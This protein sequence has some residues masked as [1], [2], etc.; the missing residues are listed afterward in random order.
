M[1][2]K[3]RTLKLMLAC[4]VCALVLCHVCVLS[5]AISYSGEVEKLPQVENGVS[6][7]PLV[8]F[9]ASFDG[10]LGAWS[11]GESVEPREAAELEIVESDHSHAVSLS[12]EALVRYA[13]PDGF[14]FESGTLELVFRADFPQLAEEPGRTIL[15]IEGEEDVLLR[16]Y[17]EPSGPTW[18]FRWTNRLFSQTPFGA[19]S[20]GEWNH[21]A[22]V[23]DSTTEPRPEVRLYH[24]GRRSSLYTYTLSPADMHTLQLGGPAPIDVSVDELTV[25]TRALSREQ[26]GFLGET[27]H[28]GKER[29]AALAD[30][31]AFDDAETARRLA[32]RRA[33]VAQLEGKVGRL[34][35]RR[36]Q[37]PR[38][39]TF[40]EGIEA[41]GIRPEDVGEIDLSQFS[42][43]YF[44]QGTGYQLERD[45]QQMIFDYVKNGGGY[46]GSCA[47]AYTA[48]QRFSPRLL[49]IRSH[50]FRATALFPISLKA[51]PVTDGYGAQVTMHHGNGPIMFPRDDS[52]VIGTYPVPADEHE[53]PG[54]I[55]VGRRGEGRLVLFGPHPLGGGIGA[56]GKSIRLTAADLG[57]DRMFVNAL[58]Y[59]AKIIHEE[60]PEE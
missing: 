60:E 31:I 58:L 9:R 56:A 37:Q 25:Y 43:I 15:A 6:R 48:I 3:L 46:V 27:L 32:E 5:P 45:Q 52:R 38:N 16:F 17:Y 19:V 12:G 59:A 55:V 21:L 28:L 22:L 10:D 39:F 11:G 42:V 33:Q 50:V 49:N 44:P 7:A 2:S 47:G 1:L 57:T 24:N 34:I 36:N 29:F 41:R 20:Q 51:H 18:R 35:A 23:W 40:P 26:A 13:L 54:A 14:P 53:P 30:R 8:F 4:V